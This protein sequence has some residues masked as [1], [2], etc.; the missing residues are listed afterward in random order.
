MD[1]KTGKKLI[2]SGA[3][4]NNLKDI[5]VNIPHNSLTVITGVS[6]SG[7]SSL[8][9]NVIF[10]ESQRR[11]FESFSSYSRQYIGKLEK[12]DFRSISGLQ[13]AVAINQK[14]QISNPRSTVG[15][16]SGVYD[17]LRLLYARLGQQY[18]IICATRL[19]KSQVICSNCGHENPKLLSK[20]FSFNSLYG[21][22]SSC[23]GL[24]VKE[25]IDI[26]KLIA[27]ENLTLRE[28]ALVPTTPVGYIV[29]SQVRVE[30]LNKVCIAHGFSVDIPWKLLTYEQKNVILYGSDRVKILFGKHSLE[31]RLKWKGITALPREESNYKG[32][33]P[34]M[35]DILNRDRNDNIQR[36]ASSFICDDCHGS[37]LKKEA[38]SVLY[39]NRSITDLVDIPLSELYPY[40]KGLISNIPEK[41]VV[42]N[43]LEQVIKRLEYL[44]LLGLDYLLLSRESTTLSTGESQR[45][46]LASQ[47]GSRL[48]G[49]LYI[50]D[51]PSIGLHSSDNK[52][53][54]HVLNSL[55][56]NGN[57]VVVVE[58]DESMIY[59]AD[60]LIDIGPKAGIE[61]G[62]VIFEGSPDSFFR[63][64]KLYPDSLTAK[65]YT[66]GSVSRIKTSLGKFSDKIS[67]KGA[68]ANNLKNI[69][70]E[71]KLSGFNVVTGVSGAGKSSLVNDVF[72][73]SIKNNFVPINCESIDS[74]K[75][76]GRVISINQSPIGRTPRSNPATYTDIFDHIRELFSKLPESKSRGYKKGRFSFNV[77]G[78]RCEKCQGFGYLELGMHFLGNVEIKCDTCN[79][80]RFNAST[81]E[82][83]YRGK[84][85]SDILQ[86]SIIEAREFFA[87]HKKIVRILD[88]LISLDV[89]YLKLGQSSTTLSGGEAQRVKLASELYRTSAGHNLYLL[90]EPSVGLHKSDTEFLINALVSI[91]D[92]DNTVVVIE[93]DLDIISQADH[94][95]DIGPL[96]GDNGG[97]LV[98]QGTPHELSKHPTSLT[99]I[100]LSE[101]TKN[102]HK[103]RDTN[104][105]LFRNIKFEGV[106]T[107][108]LKNIDIEIP[109]NKTTVVAGVSGSGKSS[110]V[111]DT[112]YSESRNRFTEGLSTYARRMMS[113]LKKPEMENCSGL[114]PVIAI[115]QS[116]F[117]TNPRSTVGTFTDIHSLY[118]LL[119]S[120]FGVNKG[121]EKTNFSASMFS[122]N[123][124]NAACPV[125]KG[126]GTITISDHDKFITNPEKSLLSGA[127]EGTIPGMYFGDSNGKFVNILKEVGST[128]NIDFSVPFS[129]LD[130]E[131]KKIA[132]HGTDDEV[133]EVIWSFKRGKRIGEH[134]LTTT[135]DGFIAYINEDYSIKQGGKR[136]V[137][138]ES[139]MSAVNCKAC[140]GH[141]YK[142]EI[143]T[144]VFKEQ[145]INE[146]TA[147]SVSDSIHFFNSILKNSNC[148]DKGYRTLIL[149]IVSRLNS[150]KEMGIGY[151]ELNRPTSSLSG[152][153]TQRLRIGTQLVSDLCGITYV[154]DEP[155][156]GLH[157]SDTLKLLNTIDKLKNNGNTIVMVEHDRDVILSADNIVDIGPGAGDKG[158][159]II[160]QGTFPEI[161]N[162]SNS[163]TGRSI[164]TAHKSNKNIRKTDQHAVS[165]V[166][167]NAN[168]LKSINVHIPFNCLTAVTG[169]SGSGKSTLV[170]DV[171]SKSY[172]SK[173]P[174]GCSSIDFD[175]ISNISVVDQSSIGTSPIST[176]ATFTGAFDLIRSRFAKLD[177]SKKHNLKK[178]HFSFNSKDGKCNECNG[179]GKNKVSMDFLSDVWVLCD[180]CHGDRYKQAILKAKY[181]QKSIIDILNMEIDRALDFFCLD[182]DINNVLK[183]ISD[184]GLGYITLGQATNSLSGG[185]IQRLKLAYELIKS[186][187]ESTM[188]IFDEP[189]TGL[190]MEDVQK[191][192]SVFESLLDKGNTVVVVEHNLDIISS[193]DYIID[194]GPEGGNNGGKVLFSGKSTEIVDSSNSLTGSALKSYTSVDLN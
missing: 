184:V 36:F 88:Q 183:V 169:V 147:R 63:N 19:S 125:C 159:R 50:L 73:K 53:L 55:R 174:V 96:G 130:H 113:K 61:G 126:L 185:E 70:V 46:K 173:N 28:G 99:G 95:I 146:I 92:N 117:T 168:N 60:Y 109:L 170:F 132:L 157:S 37:R 155:T 14:A 164:V 181:K 15:T 134:R 17:Y 7:K 39:N 58:H 54:I 79:G 167:A 131:S 77:V 107:N 29:Y 87:D 177:Y 141:R 42:E 115:M 153:E 90:D 179:M 84:N 51:E 49:M 190:H 97:Q 75:K 5:T 111:F 80:S 119:F 41:D 27:D 38:R 129:K 178:S 142:P 165:I 143:L 112:I 133:Y 160:A 110:L 48:Q 150:H 127:M 52:K 4:E 21:A 180:T 45:I 116:K 30:E 26:S 154:F 9:Y 85:I 83:E 108:N 100:A 91:V 81:L 66:P 6:G 191:L 47:V 89:G 151:L 16:M 18:C 152:G 86:L 156:I 137:T 140:N 13:A 82:I 176:P 128:K 192:L 59:E 25:Q 124:I 136:G 32:M 175:N 161:I 166:G 11:F 68:Y 98:F 105:P 186:E 94:I 120:R 188:Y 23:K 64:Q 122:F 93:H 72:A 148:T 20:L 139:I 121:G 69:N 31:S 65:Y 40:F 149:Q 187:K 56:N 162:N 8:A 114:T 43:I 62:N 67:I 3:K 10:K 2:V 163:I 57:T 172:G 135:W 123:N 193:S 103:A 118:R 12:P 34:I 104:L 101:S 33:I 194:L 182:N 44:N 189:T 78:G 71:F 74:N 102:I 158:G 1:D 76:I 24:G 144:V 138:F 106:N 22:C 171:I 145:N 35:E